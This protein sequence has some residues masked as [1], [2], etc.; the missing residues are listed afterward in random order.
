MSV[1]TQHAM[2]YY[3]KLFLSNSDQPVISFSGKAGKADG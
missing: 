1:S 2:A 3:W